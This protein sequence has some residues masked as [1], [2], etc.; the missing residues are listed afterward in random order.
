MGVVDKASSLPVVNTVLTEVSV[1]SSPVIPYVDRTVA[2]LKPWLDVAKIKVEEN[3]V[4][5]LP[6]GT[7]E[8]VKSRLE[9]TMSTLTEA[10]EKVDSYACG[11][12]D[13][14]VEKMPVL[15]EETPTLL[16]PQRKPLL[17][18]LTVLQR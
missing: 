1:L 18:R 9:T 14:L 17:H 13:Q 3:V 16:R 6:E 8:A 2:T 4:P 11:G 5:R 10:V 7:S 15:K 12:V